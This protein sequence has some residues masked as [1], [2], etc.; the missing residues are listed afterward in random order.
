M[1]KVSFGWVGWVGGG[2]YNERKI[3][4]GKKYKKKT[5][6]IKYDVIVYTTI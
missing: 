3:R 5:K 2:I 6:K 1:K 4:E